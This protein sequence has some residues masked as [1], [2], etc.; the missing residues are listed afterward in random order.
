MQ[1]VA[2]KGK[3]WT[4]SCLPEPSVCPGYKGLLT[5]ELNTLATIVAEGKTKSKVKTKS[6]SL[7][8][9]ALGFPFD[10]FSAWGWNTR[11]IGR[12]LDFSPDLC[13]YI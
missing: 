3:W 8:S 13:W 5:A 11:T 12:Y 9:A 10:M 4:A 7:A 2:G 1:C 6:K